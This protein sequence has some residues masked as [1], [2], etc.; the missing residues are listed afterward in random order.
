MDVDKGN[1][2]KLLNG[3]IQYI[4][5]VYQRKY[6]WERDRQCRRLWLDIV[7]ME[8]LG[9]KYHFLASIVNIA[10][11]ATPMGIS[12]FLVIDGQQRITT[13]SLLMIALRDYII[14]QQITD[15]NT[16][17]LTY[18]VLK[19]NLATGSDIYK[20]LLTE[21][22]RDT[23]CHLID[24]LDKK[25]LPETDKQSN[26]YKNYVYF[27]ERIQSKELSPGQVYN[28]LSKL[29]IVNITL[30][31]EDG[32]D[33]QR[34]FESLN[35]TGMALGKSD[36]IRNYILMGLSDEKQKTI[37]QLYWQPFEKSFRETDTDKKADRMDEFFRYYLM[38]KTN[39]KR[40]INEE[41]YEEFKDYAATVNSMEALT[42]DI[43]EF[44]NYFNQTISATTDYPLLNKKLRELMPLNSTVYTL[45]FMPFLIYAKGTSMPETEMYKIADII[46]NYLARRIMCDARSAALTQAFLNLHTEV[47]RIQ[48]Q[49]T[50]QNEPL[51]ASY[52]DIMTYVL[53]HWQGD[54]YFPTDINIKESFPT[55]MVYLLPGQNKA[56]LFERLENSCGPETNEILGL[57]NKMKKT[58]SIEHI[59]PQTLTADWKRELG[60]DWQRVYDT[61]LHT[62]G[63]LTLTGYNPNYS[64]KTFHEKQI[65]YVESNGTK[66]YGFKDSVYHLSIGLGDLTH[67]SETEIEERNNEICNQ[68]LSLW[69]MPT[70]TYIPLK[71][72]IEKISFIDVL[73]GF[74]LRY[75]QIKTFSFQGVE[76]V[77][78][79]WKDVLIEVSRLVYAEYPAEIELLCNEEH[80]YH[81]VKW[82]DHCS[83]FAP[84]LWVWT[85]SNTKTKI[86][87]MR[88][89]FEKTNIPFSILSFE[90]RPERNSTT[91]NEEM[92]VEFP[93]DDQA[94][95][96]SSDDTA[97]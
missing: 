21:E 16:D 71:K 78:C 29:Q 2:F 68:F 9:K 36:L 60:P 70:T 82:I 45:F 11:V 8:K 1:I 22:D 48:K 87:I 47:T 79:N 63:N 64:N 14:E 23:F 67:W 54:A 39:S 69:P 90:L 40:V 86:G 80:N 7:E 56:F 37:Y 19:N 33:P 84:G 75:R 15:V 95:E 85:A 24:Y 32:D 73:N 91:S 96:D 28:S 55:R 61:Y 42:D 93:S 76:H 83:E 88:F 81:K 44:G 97:V 89:L 41:I 35:S 49:H 62:F 13:M 92:D 59:M 3:N 20:L 65:G 18:F 58:V 27:L 50:A 74:P 94:E 51:T 43:F 25:K 34:I 30:K 6:N 17:Q 4:V 5:P 77:V 57:D 31:R 66:V 10:E 38:I 26:L 72:L 52:S 53:L 12:K 46:E